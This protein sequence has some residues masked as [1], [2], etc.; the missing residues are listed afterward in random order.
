MKIKYLLNKSNINYDSIVINHVINDIKDDSRQIKENDIFFAI[1]G[2]QTDGRKYID[3]AI[4][5]GSK[6]IIYEGE[7]NQKNDNINYINVL[8]IRSV[9][10]S[11]C[12]IFYKDLILEKL[13]DVKEDGSLVLVDY[14]GMYVPAMKGQ[15]SREIGSPDFRHPK[16]TEDNFNEHIDDFYMIMPLI[17]HTDNLSDRLYNEFINLR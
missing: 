2:G 3:E 10:A 5:K 4:K 13:I 6:T 15:K 17:K 1:N 12:K 16:R 8:N 14:D 11:F 9:L 7:I